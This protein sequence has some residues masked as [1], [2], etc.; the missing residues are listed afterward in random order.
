MK[1]KIPKLIERAKEKLNSTDP[2][3]IDF[4]IAV[5]GF[6]GLLFLVFILYPIFELSFA[7]REAGGIATGVFGFVYLYLCSRYQTTI[8]L[9]M[10]KITILQHLII[11]IASLVVLWLFYKLIRPFTLL[12]RT[13][14]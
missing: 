9:V 2:Y 1:I 13:N 14:A 5:E 10:Q 8:L 6:I 12:V 11:I 7:T 4:F 3:Y